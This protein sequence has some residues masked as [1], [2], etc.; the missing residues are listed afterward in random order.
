[1]LTKAWFKI[2]LWI[3]VGIGLLTG[4]M[5]APAYAGNLAGVSERMVLIVG[6]LCLWIARDLISAAKKAPQNTGDNRAEDYRNP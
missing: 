5:L 2:W 6:A 3:A 1:M 4:Y